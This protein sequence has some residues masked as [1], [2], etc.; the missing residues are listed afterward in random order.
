MKNREQLVF[1]RAFGIHWLVLLAVLSMLTGCAGMEEGVKDITRDVTDFFG[2]STLP[3]PVATS[4]EAM[5]ADAATVT[6]AIE[7]QIIG[8]GNVKVENIIFMQAARTKLAVVNLPAENLE[9][10]AVHLYEYRAF[11]ENPIIKKSR[12]R[13]LYEGPGGRSTSLL[14]EAQFRRG[15]NGI[16]I[17]YAEAKPYYPPSPGLELFVVEAARLPADILIEAES[18]S[19]LIDYIRPLAEPPRDSASL[20]DEVRDYDI[21]V[22]VQDKLSP[23]ARMEVKKS[24]T[25][26]SL[27]G[28]SERTRY[29]DFNGWPVAQ[30]RAR[31][32]LYSDQVS[33]PLYIKAILTPGRESGLLRRPALIGQFHL[34]GIS[35]PEQ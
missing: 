1:V 10:T 27:D 9:R 2:K 7:R 25:P 21:F 26:D 19:A 22:F 30:V 6:L 12:G 20:Y 35:E 24:A 32:R 29:R 17:D 4:L 33:P 34:A 16:I 11:P 18:Y 23:D 28:I 3:Q 15:L 14:Y 31:F 13:L 8:R 5:P